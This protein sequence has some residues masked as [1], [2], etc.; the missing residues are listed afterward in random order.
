MTNNTSEKNIWKAI[1]I[2]DSLVSQ[3]EKYTKLNYEF[4]K[5]N[6]ETPDKNCDNLKIGRDHYKREIKRG[7]LD[8][9]STFFDK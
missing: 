3:I 9:D 5:C 4:V 1:I 2:G 6:N 7:L 8:L